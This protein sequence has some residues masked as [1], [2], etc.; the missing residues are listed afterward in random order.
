MS[1][2][3]TADDPTVYRSDDEVDEWKNRCPILRFEK[4][5]K[6]RGL[7]DDAAI[8]RIGNECEQEVRDG[9]T[10][11]RERCKANPQEVFDYM[12]ATMPPELIAQ[13][14]EYLAKLKRLGVD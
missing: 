11:F 1:V 12:F 10:K 3:T 13:R 2:H 14:E 9:R 8:E 7:L 5:L 6:G 4:F